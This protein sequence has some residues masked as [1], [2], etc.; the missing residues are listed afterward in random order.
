MLNIKNNATVI[1]HDILVR[2]LRLQL[3]GLLTTKRADSIPK[4]I[5]PKEAEPL[6]CCIYH[7]REIMKLRA[8]ARLGFSIEDYD[9][10]YEISDYAKKALERKAPDIP[11]LTMLHEACNACVKQDYIVTNACQ[12]CLARPCE[13]NCPKKAIEVHKNAKID[14]QKC[15]HCGLCEQNCPYHAIIKLTVPCEAA[16]PVGAI[17]KGSDGHEIIDYH[18]CIYCG[19]CMREC[20]FGAVLDK[21]QAVDVLRCIM[22]GKRVVAMYAPSVAIQFKESIYRLEKGILQAGFS[23]VLEVAVGAD[24]CATT[25]AKEF[26]ERQEKGERLMTTSCCAAY[27][28]SISRHIPALKGCVSNT[29]SPMYYTGEVAKKEEPDCI[30]VFIGPCLSKKREGLDCPFIDYVLTAEELQ[31]LFDA[32]DIVLSSI[33]EGKKEGVLPTKSGRGFGKTGGVFEAVKVRLPDPSIIKGEVIDG[34]NK[35]NIA[36]LKLYGQVI[37]GKMKELPNFPNMIEVMACEGGCVGGP[38]TLLSSKV[39]SVLLDKYKA[40]G[41]EDKVNK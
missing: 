13:V 31:A 6:S 32:K 5:V 28:R 34:L 21:S 20:P 35:K 18:K 26:I 10:N 40:E 22:E 27:V 25:E 23:R 2:L 17:Q 16:C 37:D 7:D 4:D 41:T 24:I 29:H 12:G 9:D 36:K 11:V 39:G 8:I 38:A 14:T 15:I 30:T 33:E 19:S 1:K 3:N